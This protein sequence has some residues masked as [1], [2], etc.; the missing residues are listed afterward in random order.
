MKKS[1]I[2]AVIVMRINNLY[3]G[4]NVKHVGMI[5]RSVMNV[6]L[7]NKYKNKKKTLIEIFLY[8]Q[9]IIKWNR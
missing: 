2:I 8:A 6:L 4:Q 3:V 7:L 5:T 9:N 1:L